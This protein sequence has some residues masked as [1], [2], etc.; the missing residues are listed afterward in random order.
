M[1][2]NFLNPTPI[3][4]ESSQYWILDTFVW[5][6][7][8][9]ELSIFQNDTQLILP[10]ND[11][12]PGNVRSVHEMAQ[13]VFD[14][15]LKYA[16]LQHWPIVL[17]K[18]EDFKQRTLP[19]LEFTGIKRGEL[20]RFDVPPTPEQLIHVSYNPNQVNQP[21]DLVA[22]FAQAF[23]TIM[24]VQSGKTPPGGLE[25]IP[26]AVD[27]VAS[28]MGFGVMF[29]NTAY[30]FKG[31]CGSCFNPYANRN[32]ALSE[33]D[34]IYC[35]ALFCVVKSLPVKSV[36]IHLKSH[37]RPTFKSAYKALQKSIAGGSQATLVKALTG[38]ITAFKEY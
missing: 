10:T 2:A 37:L 36:V 16:S 18:P 1:F 17:V 20:V 28:F 7:E 29:S 11:F 14:R 35:L 5:A 31:G 15:T 21:Q 38:R 23:A 22:S 9:F 27:L 3:I 32:V 19:R 6:L 33:N 13:S 4:D 34:M 26:Q 12:Y 30:Q 8:N 25:F 24:I